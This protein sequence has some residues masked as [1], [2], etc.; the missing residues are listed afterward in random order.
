[1]QELDRSTDHLDSSVQQAA[2]EAVDIVRLPEQQSDKHLCA[3]ALKQ[4]SASAV[5]YIT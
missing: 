2:T 4:H 5:P 1:V 3:K